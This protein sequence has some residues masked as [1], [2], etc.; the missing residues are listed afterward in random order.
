M[1]TYSCSSVEGFL[2]A[3]TKHALARVITAAHAEVT[4]A[5]TYFAQVQ[6]IDRPEGNIFIGGNALNYDH[7][8]IFGHIREGRTARDRKI[9]IERLGHDV[10]E[11]AAL[12]P[13]AVW[14]YLHELPAQAMMEFGHI[15]PPAGDEDVWASELPTAEREFI[16]SIVQQGK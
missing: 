3:M 2:S 12:E 5:P 1:P 16:Q 4:G 13:T 7:L 6:F 8:F 11:V 14:V 15:L 10:A 9:L